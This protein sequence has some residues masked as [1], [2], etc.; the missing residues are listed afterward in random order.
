MRVAF[1]GAHRVGKTTLVEAVAA[2]LRGYVAHEEPY[3]ILGTLDWRPRFDDIDR[4]HRDIVA[5][6]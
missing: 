6:Q 2:R 1:A 4:K 3:R 5:C